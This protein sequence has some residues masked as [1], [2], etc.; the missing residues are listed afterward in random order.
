MK[1]L[2][3]I[4]FVFAF[5][6]S[7]LEVLAL[8][9]IASDSRIRT[10]VYGENEV[11]RLFTNYGYQSN[12]EFSRNEEVQTISIGDSSGWQ[13]TPAGNRLFVRAMEEKAHTNMTVITNKRVYQFELFAGN[14]DDDNLMYVARFY[15]PDSDFDSTGVANISGKI[16]QGINLKAPR[17]SAEDYN[18]DYLLTGAFDISPL[19]VFDDGEKTYFQFPNN[20][21]V[22]PIIRNIDATVKSDLEY[23]VV[24]EFVV[25]DLISSRFELAHGRSFVNV[26]N[27]SRMIRSAENNW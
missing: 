2:I 14:S 3:K 4:L 8:N 19:K 24:G 7:S 23:R 22:V 21:L 15:Y 17:N 12:I 20:N 10:F 11:F 6:L 26:Y 16:S 13:L 18:F 1:I 9:P 5:L 27:Q 25:V